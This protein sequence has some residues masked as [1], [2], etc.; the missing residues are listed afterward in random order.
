MAPLPPVPKQEF[1]DLIEPLTRKYYHTFYRCSLREQM[2]KDIEELNVTI[3]HAIERNN[4]YPESGDTIPIQKTKTNWV[5]SPVSYQRIRYAI[6][7]QTQ[8]R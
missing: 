6:P 3:H 5:M 4:I 8:F 1:L 7:T 2:E